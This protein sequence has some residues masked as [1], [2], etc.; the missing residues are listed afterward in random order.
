MDG[1]SLSA[2]LSCT[3]R[4]L[5]A[6]HSSGRIYERCWFEMRAS[7]L[8]AV[9]A[10]ERLDDAAPRGESSTCNDARAMVVADAILPCFLPVLRVSLWFIHSL[11]SLAFP[12]VVDG[13][14]MPL[15]IS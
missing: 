6:G 7:C 14:R 5:L 3:G 12:L 9:A 11:A 8:P 2:P 4:Y 1:H 15:N 13:R 10:G